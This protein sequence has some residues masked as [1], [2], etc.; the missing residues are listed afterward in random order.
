[1]GTFWPNNRLLTQALVASLVLHLLIAL[2]IPVMTWSASST[3]VETISFVHLMHITVATPKPKIRE[4]AATA[5]H[6]ARVL[7][8]APIAHVRPRPM[9][10]KRVHVAVRP[11]A[12]AA[13]APY[14]APA[15]PGG[16]AQQRGQPGTPAAP[17][18]APPQQEVAN[19]TK[20]D[21]GGY[22]PLGA[23][24]PDP[25]LDPAVRQALAK[26]G[27]HVTLLVTVDAAGKTES[28]DFQPPLNQS[29][30]DQIRT[31]LANASWDP[32]QC[33]GGVA[34]EGRATIKL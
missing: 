31:M 12:T 24:E 33:G 9:R 13:A 27:V 28:V 17:V 4:V 23:S 22:M 5:P 18:T 25:V 32:A 16:T 15:V 19:A 29:V 6:Y 26:L 7:H 10:I 14:V 3:T 20:H 2:V 8:I 30:E 34:C 21:V 1:M 11:I